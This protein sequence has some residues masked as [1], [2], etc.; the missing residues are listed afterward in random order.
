MTRRIASTALYIVTLVALSYLLF[1]ANVER[2]VLVCACFAVG[3]FFSMAQDEI[4]RRYE[5][6]IDIKFEG[7]K[8]NTATFFCEACGSSAVEPHKDDCSALALNCRKCGQPK[9]LTRP[10]SHYCRSCD[11]RIA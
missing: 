11:R 5:T 4:E 1:L 7:L 8:G 2:I 9:E 10:G 6:R 3:V